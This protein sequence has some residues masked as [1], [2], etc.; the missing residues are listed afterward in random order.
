MQRTESFSNC[1][2]LG[3]Y[4]GTACVLSR[5]GLRNTSGPFD[6]YISDFQGVLSQI[7][8]GFS[9]FLKRKN[10]EKTDNPKI[11]IDTKYGFVINHD[12]KNNFEDEYEEIWRKYNRRITRFK[13]TVIQPTLFFRCIQ[14]EAEIEYINEHWEHVSFLLKRY[15]GKNEI[16]YVYREGLPTL[17]SNVKSFCLNIDSYDANVLAMRHLFDKSEELVV[18]CN[19][20]LP[21]SVRRKNLEFDRDSNS[22]RVLAHYVHRQVTDDVD[23]ID[24]SILAACDADKS[25]EIFIWG[26][27]TFGMPLAGY[28]RRRGVH[29]RGIIDNN[30]IESKIDGFDIIPFDKVE[31]GAKIFVSVSKEEFNLAIEKQIRDVQCNVTIAKY[32][33]LKDLWC[34][35]NL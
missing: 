35:A 33:D 5:L 34:Q 3:Y 20:L 24:E 19:N 13:Q 18:F 14:N 4:C 23:G 2:S 6:W 10:L 31:D 12:I 21:T 26:A 25:S 32:A 11:I 15:N 8:N 29:I 17:T 27:G 9:D 16:V 1:I 28:L 7:E 30:A 22:Q